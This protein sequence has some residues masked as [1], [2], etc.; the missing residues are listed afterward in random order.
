VRLN[1]REQV[2]AKDDSCLEPQ[3]ARCTAEKV[4]S[5]FFRHWGHVEHR[6]TR[7][8]RALRTHG[9]G[10]RGWPDWTGSSL[11]RNSN[12][13]HM[14]LHFGQRRLGALEWERWLLALFANM[15]CAS[16]CA[17]SLSRF[18]ETR[19]RSCWAYCSGCEGECTARLAYPG[20]SDRSGRGRLGWVRTGFRLGHVGHGKLCRGRRLRPGCQHCVL[21]SGAGRLDRSRVCVMAAAASS[22]FFLACPIHPLGCR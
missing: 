16:L 19:A 14:Q 17:I 1:H 21:R 10:D 5:V 7:C 3:L 8:T 18:R 15:R 11:D 12:W 2:G 13:I 20:V 22:A 9:G 4:A 6:G